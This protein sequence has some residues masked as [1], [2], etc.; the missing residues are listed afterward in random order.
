MQHRN[1]QLCSV[2]IIED[3]PLTGEPFM[4]VKEYL[5]KNMV[6]EEVF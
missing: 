4:I 6:N 2:M 1:R 5:G 3:D